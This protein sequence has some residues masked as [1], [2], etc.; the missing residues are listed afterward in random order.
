MY[1][2]CIV[3][4]GSIFQHGITFGVGG[5]WLSRIHYGESSVFIGE[6]EFVEVLQWLCFECKLKYCAFLHSEEFQM[7]FFFSSILK[8]LYSMLILQCKMCIKIW[9]C[10]LK[11]YVPMIYTI[12]DTNSL[13]KI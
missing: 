1:I 13:C 9:K 7:Q 4:R 3:G 12:L 10:I 2:I 5:E 8:V 6:I 11:Y